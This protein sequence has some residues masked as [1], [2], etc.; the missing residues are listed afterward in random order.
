MSLRDVYEGR[1]LYHIAFAESKYIAF[2]KEIYKNLPC[3]QNLLLALLAYARRQ[4]YI[5]FKQ[6]LT[7]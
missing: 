5:A 6:N 7:Y 1:N 3:G 4:P 2:P